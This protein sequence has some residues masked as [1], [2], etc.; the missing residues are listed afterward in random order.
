MGQFGKQSYG[1][2]QRIY[3]TVAAAI[4]GPK[5]GQGPFG[6]YFDNI[7]TDDTMGECSF[8]KAERALVEHAVQLAL[9]KADLRESD[10]TLHLGGDLL[11]QLTATAYAA[12]TVGIPFYGLYS[13]CA[14]FG[15]ALAL[16]GM[17]LESGFARHLLCTASSHFSSAERQFRM[18]LELGNQRAPSAQR[19]VTGAGAVVLS[20]QKTQNPLFVIT[21]GTTG[22]VVDYGVTD[23]NDLGAAMAPA[24]AQT[25]LAH[26]SDFG[27][28]PSDYD[29]IIT[30]DLGLFGQKLLF[31]L[32][33]QEGFA[34]FSNFED[35]GASVFAPEQGC[36]SGGSGCG[37]CAIMLCG[38][39]ARRLQ[40][41]SWRRVLF[42]PTGALL[43]LTS[44]QQGESIPGLAHAVVLEA[45]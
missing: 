22:R 42:V 24:A 19:T 38:P 11:N 10:V 3:A 21:G 25:L 35:C 4:C 40:L 15:S 28:Q 18:P 23:C 44:V 29:C 41:G 1:F 30:G 16:G 13:A 32:L 43:S 14:T 6:K 20:T 31:D 39:F 7:V 5:E 36:D 26:F 34:N 45:V 17:L 8:D 2:D 33:T 27:R 37:C 9:T 12:R